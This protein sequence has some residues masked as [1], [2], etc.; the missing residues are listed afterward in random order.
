MSKAPTVAWRV[1]LRQDAWIN[2]EAIVPKEEAHTKADAA[3]AVLDVWRGE[4]SDI[5]LKRVEA[6]GFDHAECEADDVE[7]L[8]AEDMEVYVNPDL[9]APSTPTH[10]TTFAEA[11]QRF[12]AGPSKATAA[13]YLEFAVKAEADDL[14]GDDEFLNALGELRDWLAQA[15]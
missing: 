7:A 15:D 11:Q 14:I 9:I 12:R 1:T 3:R 4:R 10:P 6:N 2:H 8:T 13:L 5:E